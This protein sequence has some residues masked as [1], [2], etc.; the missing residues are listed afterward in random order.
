MPSVKPNDLGLKTI[1]F[2]ET[3]CLVPEG[4]L[5]GQPMRLLPFQKD[6]IHDLMADNTREAYLSI[7]KKNGKTNLLA[8][9]ILAYLIGPPSIENA[10]II[11]V[12]MAQ[13]QAMILYEYL[14]K[15]IHMNDILEESVH[16]QKTPPTVTGLNT[17]SRYRVYSSKADTIQG[18]SP[19]IAIFDEIGEVVGSVNQLVNNIQSAQSAYSDYKLICIS[20]QA[21]TDGDLFSIWIDNALNNDDEKIRCHLYTSDPEKAI[22]DKKE[23]K[24][25]NPALGS[26]KS[27][28]H[29]ESSVKRALDMPSEESSFRHFQ[30]NQRISHN[31][32]YIPKSVWQKNNGQLAPELTPEIEENLVWIGGLDLG[33]SRDLTAYVRVAFYQK[34]LY[35]K[36]L[37]WLPSDGIVQRVQLYREPFDVWAKQGYII[38]THGATVDYTD[39]ANVILDDI[40]AGRVRNIAF[41]K[42]NITY[43]QQCMVEL[44]ATKSE[45]DMM[46]TFAQ[47]YKTMDPAMRRL[48]EIMYANRLVH[49][50]NPVLTMCSRNSIVKR[51]NRDNR[52]LLKIADT[53]PIDGIVAL[54]MAVGSLGVNVENDTDFFYNKTDLVSKLLN[55][56][57]DY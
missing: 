20:T 5:V 36:P 25:A 16:I 43:L 26:F 32:P 54:I 12:A 41:D 40:R 19:R 33:Q 35:V 3:F 34:Y 11:S 39:V 24:K 6:F 42:W 9:L 55:F 13:K 4:E 50:D 28:I 8:A 51:D 18:I 23:W 49:Y 52:M 46:T 47:G 48:D 22:D 53:K 37:F 14:C 57:D 2:I 44:G 1:K 15:I 56:N 30:L 10:Q 45:L 29:M 7:A 21:A 27:M 31:D 38:L 17:N